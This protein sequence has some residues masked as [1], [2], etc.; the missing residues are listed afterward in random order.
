LLGVMPCC[1][2]CLSVDKQPASIAYAVRA[3]FGHACTC[4]LLPRRALG[5]Q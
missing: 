1:N 4:T 5:D 3:G 2:C